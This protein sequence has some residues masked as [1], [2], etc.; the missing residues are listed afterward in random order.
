MFSVT[1]DAAANVPFQGAPSRSARS[2]Q[3]QETTV[4]RALVDSNAA[5]RQHARPGAGPIRPAT[6]ARRHAGARGQ[7]RVA[8][9]DRDRPD[10]QETI[11]TIP[12]PAPAQPSDANAG[13]NSDAA[14]QSTAKSGASKAAIR[15]QPQKR[16]PTAAI[17]P[18]I[19]NRRHRLGTDRADRDDAGRGRRCDCRRRRADWS[20][21]R[22]LAGIRQCHRAACD[23]GS[24]HRR[25]HVD[26]RRCGSRAPAQTDAVPQRYGGSS[27]RNQLGRHREHESR[28]STAASKRRRR[29]RSQAT[30]PDT[31][32]D[33]SRADGAS[34]ATVAAKTPVA[35]ESDIPRLRP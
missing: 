32:T 18:P 25:Q 23:C 21:S 30:Q 19:F 29:R 17:P 28:N 34:A 16:L 24:G 5:D 11:R 35:A 13:G 12:I 6:P 15:N 22:G 3:S 20:R 7:Q 1:S 8:E 9:H 27:R 33:H 2:D 26:H 10:R 31:P 4:L 14:Q